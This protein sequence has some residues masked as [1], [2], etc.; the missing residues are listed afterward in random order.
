MED[1]NSKSKIPNPTSNAF[2]MPK[3]GHRPDEYE[4]AFAA[5]IGEDGS[6]RAAVADGA[7]ESAYARSWARQLVQGCVRAGVVSTADVAAQLTAW[8]AAWR[9]AVAQR[10]TDAAWYAAIK[11]DEGAYATLLSLTVTPDGRWRAGAVG[12]SC[13]LHLRE[14]TLHT[15]WPLE[16]SDQFTHQPALIAS[17]ADAPVPELLEQSG[18][19]QPGDTLLLVTDALASWL[20]QTDPAR[21]LAWT[22][23]SFRDE[24][25]AARD[26]STLR[27]DDVT[28]L[29]LTWTAA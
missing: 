28:A 16:A 21:A 2:W 23:R 13:L 22:E 7:T 20:L 24:V 11:A 4:D 17:R 18:A 8:R 1:Q 9:E 5:H 29:I 14:G 12:D 19:C 27:N 3:A 10:T 6:V 25:R 15:A 26:D